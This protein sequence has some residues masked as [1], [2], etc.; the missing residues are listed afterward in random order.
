MTDKD[1]P[2]FAINCMKNNSRL[3]Q[4]VANSEAAVREYLEQA[5]SDNTRIAY[6]SDL[7]HFESWGG[8]I[9]STPETLVQY[10]VAHAE[11]LS[12]A[13]LIR[14]VAAISKAHTLRGLTSPAATDL[15][16][17][18]MRGIKRKM[19]KPQS[20]VAP[21]MKEDLIV[22]L[23]AIPDDLRGCRDRALLLTG[24]CAALR[25]TELCRVRLEDIQ[26]TGEGIVLTLPRSK[27][28]QTGEGRKIGIPFGRGKICPVQSMQDWLNRAGIT[29]GYIFRGIDRGTV[30][31]TPLCDR[32]IANI[33]KARVAK[34]GLN[35]ALYSG[36]SLRAGLATSAAAEGIPSHRIRAQTGHKS[37]AMLARY[38]RDGSLFNGNAAALF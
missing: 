10:L 11:I 37:D 27:T 31:E 19:G 23:S 4:S 12:V 36:H 24:F 3:M 30:S 32:S 28:D 29:G 7:R 14:R 38:I 18:T 1:A 35:P 34:V 5:L 15:V 16:R 21:L 13:T 22:T 6:Q 17:L 25:R 9:P 20:Q 26:F 2:I 33:I 8:E